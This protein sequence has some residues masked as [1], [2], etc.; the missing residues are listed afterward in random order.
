[1]AAAHAAAHGEVVADQLVAFD[2]GDESQ[3]LV[4]TSMSL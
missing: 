1:M 3:A 2:D 4:N